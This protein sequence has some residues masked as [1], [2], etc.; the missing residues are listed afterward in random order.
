MTDNLPITKQQFDDNIINFI[1][2][3]KRLPYLSEDDIGVEF[4]NDK[5]E[6][7]LRPYRASRYIK[8][9]YGSQ[10]KMSKELLKN[11]VIT[12]KSIADVLGLTETLVANAITGETA[13]PQK[14]VRRGIDLFFNKDYYEKLGKYATRCGSCTSRS[15]KQFYWV[16][17]TSCKNY[18]ERK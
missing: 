4:I 2:I 10:D 3:Y 9:F 5:K 15:C 12:Y 8:E 1:N 7:E 18:K 11:K 14:E 16:E 13:N 6:K 17:V